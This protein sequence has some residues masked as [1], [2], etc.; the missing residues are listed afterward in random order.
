MLKARDIF[1]AA[2]GTGSLGE[3]RALVKV[4]T[5]FIDKNSLKET[6]QDELDMD[7]PVVEIHQN[8]RLTLVN[9]IFEDT[10]DP[11]FLRISD[12]V[13]TFQKNDTSMDDEKSP[14]ISLTIMP[15]E[16]EGG[17]IHGVSGVAIL[18]ST[19]TGGD[20]DT[21]SVIFTNDCIH[22]YMLDLEQ[23]DEEELDRA[24]Y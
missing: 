12:M 19:K 5:G 22:A 20:L 17:F 4:Q 8:I 7:N 6:A 24:D 18:Q 10:K 9:L 11:D 14:E 21:V 1:K 13:R 23:M 2:C 16:I 3:N 15:K